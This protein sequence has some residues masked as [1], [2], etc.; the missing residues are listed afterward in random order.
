MILLLRQMVRAGSLCFASRLVPT[1]HVS[2]PDATVA[3]G[4]CVRV[5]DSIS[6]EG[7]NLV[8][9]ERE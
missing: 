6:D 9:E 3:D 4:R 8:A 5:V 2:L 7:S 1:Y